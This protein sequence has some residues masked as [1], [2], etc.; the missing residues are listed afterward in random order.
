MQ[1]TVSP[2]LMFEGQAEE[3]MNFYVK[4]IPDSEIL[5]VQRHG[6]RKAPVPKAPSSSRPSPS[7]ACR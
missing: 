5:N 2:F 7:V 4:V 6:P 3:A 1:P